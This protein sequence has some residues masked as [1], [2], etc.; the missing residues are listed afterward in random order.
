LEP[1]HNLFAGHGP[2]GGNV[3][4]GFGNGLRFDVL[5]GVEN[6]FG[7]GHEIDNVYAESVHRSMST[8][9]LSARARRDLASLPAKDALRLL[10]RLIDHAAG[11]AAADVKPLYGDK[12]GYRLRWGDWRLLFDQ[13]DDVLIVRRIGHRREIYE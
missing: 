12:T 10:M 5:V 4:F 3:G 2:T 8:I 6:G 1:L 9:K 13:V 7:L 11:E